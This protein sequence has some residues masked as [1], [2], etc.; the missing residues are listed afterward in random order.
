MRVKI[1]VSSLKRDVRAVYLHFFKK[2]NEREEYFL[3]WKDDRDNFL[4][5]IWGDFDLLVRMI[6]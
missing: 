1:S 5:E 2:G 6:K 4:R 3:K